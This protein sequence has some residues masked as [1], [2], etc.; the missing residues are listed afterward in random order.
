MRETWRVA[1]VS[2][3]DLA[4]IVCRFVETTPLKKVR[5]AGPVYQ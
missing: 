5:A 3:P 4:S 2:K 1:S